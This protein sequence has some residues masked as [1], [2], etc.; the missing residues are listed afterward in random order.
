MSKRSH[1]EFASDYDFQFNFGQECEYNLCFQADNK[2]ESDPYLSNL[3]LPRKNICLGLPSKSGLEDPDHQYDPVYYEVLFYQLKDHGHKEYDDEEELREDLEEALCEH[4]CGSEL[5]HA[6]EA[7][8]H[9]CYDE[10]ENS[11]EY[12]DD[13][14]SSYQ[15]YD[16]QEAEEEEG[17]PDFECQED[18]HRWMLKIAEHSH[19]T[20][21]LKDFANQYPVWMGCDK[22]E[23]DLDGGVMRAM[24]MAENLSEDTSKCDID[25]ELF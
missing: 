25:V 2:E 6:E 9:E 20:A 5:C 3:D 14:D 7:F 4:F 8:S 22:A 16:Q 11:Y 1:S 13:Y 17:M 23:K 10:Y 15:Y 21:V 19:R 12:D 24:M 18:M